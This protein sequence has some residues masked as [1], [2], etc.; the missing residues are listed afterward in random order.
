MLGAGTQC[1]V[2]LHR[3]ETEDKQISLNL[4][5]VLDVK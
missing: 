2:S 4:F 5:I 1:A 3:S